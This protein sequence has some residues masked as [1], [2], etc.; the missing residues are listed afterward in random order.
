M[1]KG[2]SVTVELFRGDGFMTST[3]TG[4][5]HEVGEFDDCMVLYEGQPIGFVSFPVDKLRRAAE[6][7][8]AIKLNA[9]CQGMLEGYKGIK[10]MDA[11]MPSRFYLHDWIPGAEDDRPIW[12]RE[13]YFKYNEYD[14][15]DYANI[16]NRPEWDFEN[17][18]LEIIP[19]PPKSTAKPH[20][21]VY[22]SDGMLVS[23]VAAKN[24]YYNDLLKFMDKYSSFDVKATRIISD[25][26]GRIFF[27]IEII[28]K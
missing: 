28:G 4:Y 7:G 8:Y 13:N 26:D 9:T 24:G 12:M 25:E 1:R 11:L 22:A 27:R 15:A 20:I 18:K 19:T 23:E 16:V 21:G 10:G 3:A 6:L 5:R 2:Q 14:V 17:A